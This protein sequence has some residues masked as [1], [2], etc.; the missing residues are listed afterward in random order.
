MCRPPSSSSAPRLAFC[1]AAFLAAAAPVYPA[2]A[3]LSAEP[4]AY[5][6]AQ[7]SAPVAWLPWGDAALARAK[8]EQKPIFLSIGTAPSELSRAMHRQSFANPE[9]AA[10][11]ND[12]FVCIL[13]DA[14]ERPDLAA[15]FQTYVRTVKQ[16]SGLPLNLFLTPELKPFE[17]AN[18][19]PPTEEWGKE[20]FLTVARR[21]ANA[22]KADPAAQRAKAAE[23][24]AAVAAAQL[25]PA[26][27]AIDAAA[28]ASLLSSAQ[29]AIRARADT[30]HG[31]F[32]EPPKYPEPELLRFLLQDAATRELAVTTLRAILRSPLRD[33]LDGGFFRYAQDAEWRQPYFQKNLIDQARLALALL[34]A[35]QLTH[36][37]EFA[38]A[39]SDALTF[40][41][42]RLAD[43]KDG[44]AAGE[45]ATAETAAGAYFWS[46][47]ELREILGESAATTFATACGATAEG[48]V[49]ADA[50]PG[51]TTTGK[52]ILARVNPPGDAAAEQA[53]ALSAT[54]LLAQRDRRPSPV[55]DDAATSGAHGV[56]LAALSRAGTELHDAR[57]AAAAKSEYAFLR[58]HL[59]DRNVGLRRL[60]HRSTAAAPEDYALAAD[61][62]LAFHRATGEA[63]AETLARSLLA[64][65]TTRFFDPSAGRFWAVPE[66]GDSGIWTR[67][68]AP[69]PTA[70]EPPSPEAAMLLAL[71]AAPPP[72]KSSFDLASALTASIAAE[73]KDATDAPR[74]DL[75]LALKLAS[76]DGVK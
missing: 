39:A 47:A 52:N 61:G 21:A 34:D 25:S 29:E 19:L 40:S 69:T 3:P 32:G 50:F 56:L 5:L 42:K 70:G 1:L 33:P 68:H 71:A 13:V 63:K 76:A 44:F 73:V 23:A 15:L 72:D 46:L 7:A 17:G 36:D 53:F 57:F 60:A 2:A 6:R 58:D 75:L 43:S 26:P 74:G 16:L 49:P 55:R 59:L 51:V 4:S 41:L 27:A 65:A 11:L 22:W 35:A 18:Y 9:T 66:A 8:Q 28:L 38:A 24:V 62:L 14:K 20:G 10:F 64:A 30:A 37:A 48:N 31:G 12:T 45:D 67:V 54:K